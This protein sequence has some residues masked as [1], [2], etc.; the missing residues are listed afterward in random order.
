MTGSEEAGYQE[1]V[2]LVPWDPNRSLRKVDPMEAQLSRGFLRCRPEKWFPGFATHWLPLAHSLGVE[3][4]VLEVKPVM[5]AP[6]GMELGFAASVDDE[7]LAIFLDPQSADGLLELVVPGAGQGGRA[8]VAEYLA[9]RLVTSLAACWSG[10]EASVVRFDPALNPHNLRYIAAV[11]LTF[12]LN[13]NPCTVWLLAGKLLIERMDGLWRRQLCAASKEHPDSAT[14]HLELAHLTVP[15]SNLADYVTPGT[16]I[17]LE[18]PVTDQLALVMND[19][20][21][22]ACRMCNLD[23]VLGIEVTAASVAPALLPEGTTRLSIEFGTVQLSRD[24]MAELG[25]I[26]AL[27]NTGVPLGDPVEMLVNGDSVGKATLATYEGRFAI[28]VL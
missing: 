24:Q 18:Q 25:Q 28:S 4:K 20:Y 22:L 2:G 3:L 11:K 6:K 13:G 12:S 7:P 9:R 10:S 21:W 1:S 14:V 27:W 26:G 8:V 5:A 17:D 15:P 19:S 23:G 16:T